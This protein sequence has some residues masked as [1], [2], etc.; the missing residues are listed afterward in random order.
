MILQLT[1]PELDILACYISDIL[2]CGILFEI[3]RIPE[4][5]W[6]ICL[7]QLQLHGVIPEMQVIVVKQNYL[8]VRSNIEAVK[9]IT[10]QFV[11]HVYFLQSFIVSG[12]LTKVLSNFSLPMSKVIDLIPL[13]NN[14]Y[15][16]RE[17]YR[18]VI[19]FWKYIMYERRNG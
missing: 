17:R 12:K 10:K 1:P 11:L 14:S 8:W 13:L 2:N 19:H 5:N 6:N 4:Q 18:I 9:L 3:L 7:D 16:F 15:F